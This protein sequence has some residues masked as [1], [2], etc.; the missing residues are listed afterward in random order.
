MYVVAVA[1]VLLSPVSPSAQV[2]GVTGWLRDGLGLA[3]IR[4]GWVEFG[5]NV[6]MFLPLGLLLTLLFR[7][8]WWGLALAV[9]ISVAAE[10]GQL[11][12]PARTAT[13]RD[14]VA[15]G[16]G[17]LLGA[18]VAW[19]IIRHSRRSRRGRRPATRRAR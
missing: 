17:A 10:L 16:L 1:V 19:L 5:G 8:P 9:L 4:Q 14:V 12:L 15:N 18:G 6:A 11:L 13:P 2:D 3:W 7:P